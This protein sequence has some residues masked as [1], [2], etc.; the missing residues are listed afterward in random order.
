MSF[1]SIRDQDVA[2]RL[3]RNIIRRNRVP[4]G[5]LFWGPS[6]VGK[7]ITALEFA[8]ALNCVQ[9]SSEACGKCL[10]C[11]KTLDG[12]HPDVHVI[13]PVSKSRQILKDTIDFV[14]DLSMYR[15]FEGAWRVFLIL[16]ADRMGIEAQNH[17]LK[18][19]EE[20]PSNTVFIL[21]TEY[22]R[23]LL[24]TIRSRCQQV[25]FGA[26][27]PDT[28][29]EL[30]LQTH[31]LPQA[32]AQAIAAV[33]QGQMSRAIDLV[34][35][36]KRGI[37][38]NVTERLQNGED[39]LLVS[40]EFVEHLHAQ[41][42]AIKASLKAESDA[43]EA[44]EATQEETEDQKK[45]LVALAEAMVRRDVMEYLYLL[46]TW[47]RDVMVYRETANTDTVMNRDQAAKMSSTVSDGMEARLNAI[48][49]AWVYIE[50]NLSTDRVFRDLF[51]SLAP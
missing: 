32:T 29:M 49:K 31:D 38:L 6:G 9:K 48:E 46:K 35:S 5:L 44:A 41:A 7:Q 33:A 11:R 8:K 36:E 4:N 15:P 42:D 40:E 10:S 21:I 17:F 19:L 25:R 30:L 24:P 12:N 2:L 20:P 45:E 51:F 13:K 50:R 27:R 37:V 1:S 16:D 43:E 47:Y 22:P 34:V 18:T 26:L 28:V 39:P 14:N 3:L 23:Q